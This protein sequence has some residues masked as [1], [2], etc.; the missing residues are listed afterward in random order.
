MNYRYMDK[1]KQRQMRTM[2]KME[3]LQIVI[4]VLQQVKDKNL[5]DYL[6]TIMM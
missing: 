1:L 3:K 5:I 6:K 2:A 4:K